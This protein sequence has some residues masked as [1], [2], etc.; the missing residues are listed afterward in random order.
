[1]RFAINYLWAPWVV[2]I[3][4]FI[5]SLVS[6]YWLQKPVSTND[7]GLLFGAVLAILWV[8]RYSIIKS[9]TNNQKGFVL[10]GSLIIALGL[11]VY[12]IG[13]LSPVIVLEVWAYFL[14][15]SGM[16]MAMA[17]KETWRSAVF[18]SISGTVLVFM[19]KIGPEMLSS[20][21]AVNIASAST[22]ILNNFGIF[23]VS[24]GV[25][26]YFGPY[27]AEVSHACSGMNSIFSL[28][29]LSLLYLREG[30]ERKIWHILILVLLAIPIAIFTNMLRV[31]MLVLTTILMGNEFS[32]GIFHDFA[33]IIVFII[34]LLLL[35]SIDQLLIEINRAFLRGDNDKI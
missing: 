27:T 16:V 35:F 18:I 5:N 24:H 4:L 13:N 6:Y 20:T 2:F 19:G 3:I 15:A 23:I 12:I 17:P 11:I 14:L 25:K 22:N 7:E 21:L 34:A 30:V 8:E 1:M 26:L 32:Q 31:I 10:Y 9:V 28:L 29:A 33:G